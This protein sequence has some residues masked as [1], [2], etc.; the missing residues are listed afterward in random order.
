[1]DSLDAV[2]AAMAFQKAFGVELPG[3]SAVHGRG[4]TGLNF[5]FQTTAQIN[6][7][8]LCSESQQ[9]AKQPELAEGLGRDM[10]RRANCRNRVRNR[11]PGGVVTGSACF[12]N[13]GRKALLLKSVSID[14]VP[15]RWPSF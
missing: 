6:E 11:P 9:R 14:K 13:Y 2:E 5:T 10:A 1:M 12:S 7:P 15:E 3:T 4:W 8:P